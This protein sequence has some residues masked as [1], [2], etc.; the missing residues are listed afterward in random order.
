MDAISYI[1]E[2][3]VAHRDLKLENIFLDKMI[4]CKVADFGLMKQFEGP[5]AEALK[6]NCGTLNYMAPELSNKENYAGPPVDIFACGVMLFM[7]LTSKQP[8]NE[9]NDIWHQRLV[10]KPELAMQMREIPIDADALDLIAHMVAIDPAD[11]YTCEQIR[12]HKWMAGPTAEISDVVKDFT[13]IEATK[14]GDMQSQQEMRSK[15]IRSAGGGACRKMGSAEEELH[16]NQYEKEEIAD[17]VEALKESERKFISHKGSKRAFG[18]FATTKNPT[19]IFEHLWGYL[20]S[21]G[22]DCATNTENNSLQFAVK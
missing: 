20:A 15:A 10:Q 12:A 17:L 1:H 2:K 5:N 11:R 9:A 13:T 6:T 19:L 16:P 14:V 18:S 21:K 4:R 8:F 7:M 22:Y 3:G